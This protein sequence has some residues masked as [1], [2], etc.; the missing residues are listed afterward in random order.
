M[1]TTAAS[2]RN[3]QPESLTIVERVHNYLET[4]AESQ[5]ATPT[6]VKFDAAFLDRRMRQF[7]EAQHQQE[8]VLLG[9]IIS[10]VLQLEVLALEEVD[11]LA[12]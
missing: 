7:R 1:A 12:D 4:R 5:L 11:E 3:P 8:Q 2:Y 9:A 6:V 10:E